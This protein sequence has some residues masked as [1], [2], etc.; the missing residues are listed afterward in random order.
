MKHHCKYSGF[1]ISW[2]FARIY[3]GCVCHS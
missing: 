1:D 2:W 3:P